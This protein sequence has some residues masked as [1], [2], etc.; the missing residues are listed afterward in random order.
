[1]G[2]GSAPVALRKP[3]IRRYGWNDLAWE[4]ASTTT[5][6]A[7]APQTLIGFFALPVSTTGLSNGCTRPW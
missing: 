5:C 4:S 3:T 1:M 2:A 7:D 6:S